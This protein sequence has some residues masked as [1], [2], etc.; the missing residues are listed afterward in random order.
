MIAALRVAVA[1]ARATPMTAVDSGRRF[2]AGMRIM[3][4]AENPRPMAIAAV[5]SR[6]AMANATPRQVVTDESRESRKTVR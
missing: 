6:S 5:F 2:K 1:S 3:M 4:P